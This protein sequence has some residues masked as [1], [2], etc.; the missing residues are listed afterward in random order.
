MFAKV[1]DAENEMPGKIKSLGI[2]FR[3]WERNDDGSKKGVVP[4]VQHFLTGPRAEK[5]LFHAKKMFT[6]LL[7]GCGNNTIISLDF[8][9]EKCTHTQVDELV[10]MVR[11]MGL[12]AVEVQTGR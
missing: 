3:Q 11:T 7:M 6:A 8:D 12:T 1:V 4:W 2:V 10:R 9:K 5:A